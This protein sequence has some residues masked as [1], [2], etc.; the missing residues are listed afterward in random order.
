M[1]AQFPVSGSGVYGLLVTYPLAQRYQH[2][3]AR[4][5]KNEALETKSE[6]S[7]TIF[8]IKYARA[9]T[10]QTTSSQGHKRNKKK[11]QE[12]KWRR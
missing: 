5:Y 8:N 4:D 12:K 2:F 10:T 1:T 7:N 3:V 11:K 9:I 6:H